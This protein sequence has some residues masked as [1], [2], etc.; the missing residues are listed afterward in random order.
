MRLKALEKSGNDAEFKACVSQNNGIPRYMTPE[1]T[2]KWMNDQVA[3]Y[4]EIMGKA[5]ILKEK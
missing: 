4:R 1:Q 2:A 3:V 5:G